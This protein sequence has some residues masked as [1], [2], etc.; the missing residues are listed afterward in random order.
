MGRFVQTVSVPSFFADNATENEVMNV[1]STSLASKAA[2]SA[3]CQGIPSFIFS[4]TDMIYQLP[5]ASDCTSDAD[6]NNNG[7]CKNSQCLCYSNY[8]GGDCSLTVAQVIVR[9]KLRSS[10]MEH[11]IN[12][13]YKP[14]V[15]P[16]D[17][18][19]F[20]SGEEPASGP[21]VSQ[22][23]SVASSI[24]GTYYEVNNEA[25]DI[26]TPFLQQILTAAI[27]NKVGWAD[28]LTR[29]MLQIV[30]VILDSMFISSSADPATSARIRTDIL[31][32][33]MSLT[34]GAKVVNE[35]PTLVRIRGVSV[36]AQ[37]LP[38][39]PF[40]DVLYTV[41]KSSVTLPSSM[42]QQRLSNGSMGSSSVNVQ[43]ATHSY[44]LYDSSDIVSNIV[45]INLSGS[46]NS[47]PMMLNIS[48]VY[49]TT[50]REYACKQWN[51]ATSEWE[52]ASQCTLSAV[53]GTQAQCQCASSAGDFMVS[54]KS[55]IISPPAPAENIL[56]PVLGS[57]LG[58]LAALVLLGVVTGL[59]LFRV[60]WVRK[61]KKE[62][63]QVELQEINIEESQPSSI[64]EMILDTSTHQ[65]K[66]NIQ[67][68]LESIGSNPTL[69]EMID[70]ARPH[71]PGNQPVFDEQ[72][73]DSS[74]RN[75]RFDEE[76]L[77]TQDPVFDEESLTSINSVNPVL[78]FVTA[79]PQ[80]H[81]VNMNNVHFEEASLSTEKDIQSA[82]VA[83]SEEATCEDDAT[84]L[85]DP[86]WED[87]ITIVFEIEDDF[88]HVLLL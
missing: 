87:R 56:G 69:A 88:I 17:S 78:Q 16:Q 83:P 53:T 26:V 7:R 61:S 60:Y 79:P 28:S 18:S 38:L 57:V 63:P 54:P 29:Q 27:N 11:Y 21:S 85:D 32:K 19:F 30:G 36:L 58:S 5:Y 49:D 64:A 2:S 1:I 68:E 51:D 9:R 46:Q 41:G 15:D 14:Q 37:S 39:R 42:F 86:D 12:C 33:I 82:V 65:P 44:N 48:G 24:L 20:I 62:K 35:D 34:L 71:L 40:P 73:I 8:V 13:L 3:P 75:N 77:S 31:P 6:C 55:L 4:H 43:L 10:L 23:L 76:S 22:H 52:V 84:F 72:T 66:E 45:S 67:F 59:V 81:I 25:P 47:D 80:R 50:T 74:I 70:D